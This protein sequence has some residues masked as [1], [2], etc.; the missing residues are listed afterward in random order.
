[1]AAAGIARRG[2]I[3]IALRPRPRFPNFF[4]VRLAMGAHDSF[5]SVMARLRDGDDRAARQV[6]E[7]FARRL[8][9]LARVSLDGRIAQKV[10]P[11]D[12]VQ[13]AYKSF[14]VR[15][16]DAD[17]D[18]GGWDGLWGLLTLIT[19]RKCADRAEFYRAGKRDVRREMAA[20][21]HDSAAADFDLALDRDP[22]PDEAAILSETVELLFRSSDDADER[23]ILEL[24]LQGYSTPEI[25][26]RTG[27][28]ERSVR[29]LRERT[30]LRLERMHA[31]TF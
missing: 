17:W 24:S 3:R 16:R 18:I 7:R 1:M 31:E 10:D 8:I 9:G 4:P 22:R 19:L 28:A 15:H 23:A 29:R 20:G 6:F 27:R 5:E 11:E 21:P 26:E 12:L 14:F 30:R 13:S 2:F 25:S